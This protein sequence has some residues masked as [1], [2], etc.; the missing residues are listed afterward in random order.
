MSA[1]VY[2]DSPAD[3]AAVLPVQFVNYLT[4]VAADP[5]SISCV[6]SVRKRRTRTCASP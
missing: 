4:G 6:M 2:Y 5:S 1:Q 3:A